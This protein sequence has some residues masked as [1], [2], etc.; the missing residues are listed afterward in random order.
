MGTTMGI[1]T[2][3]LLAS[4]FFI[5]SHQ[6]HEAIQRKSFYIKGGFF[7]FHTCLFTFWLSLVLSGIRRSYWMYFEPAVAFR[8][9]QISSQPFVIALILSGAGI[10]LSLLILVFLILLIFWQGRVKNTA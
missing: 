4:I 1:N 5:L 3:I 10:F 2:T 8:E 7:L 6:S 9:M